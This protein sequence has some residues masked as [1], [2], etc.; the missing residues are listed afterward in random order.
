VKRYEDTCEFACAAQKGD[1]VSAYSV[2]PLRRQ[3]LDAIPLKN[4]YVIQTFSNLHTNVEV[5]KIHKLIK[6]VQFHKFME[7]D[8]G[9]GK[10]SIKIGIKLCSRNSNLFQFLW[11]LLEMGPKTKIETRLVSK[12][13]VTRSIFLQSSI[14]FLI[15][16]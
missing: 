15:S 8:F 14:T 6:L 10:V 5:W 16:S 1:T 4:W 7:L 13:N 3:G 11:K 9:P 2:R 12:F